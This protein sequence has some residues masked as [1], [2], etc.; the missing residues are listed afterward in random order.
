M[1]V[2]FDALPDSARIWIYQSNRELSLNEVQEIEDKATQFIQDWT[3]H[4]DN[5]KA[6]FIVKYQHFIIIAV[7]EGFNNASGCSI[8]A[9]VSFI[10]KLEQQFEIDLMNKLN[11]S[12][13]INNHINVVSLADFKNYIQQGK[14][15]EQTTVFNNLVT[16]IKEFKR[17]WE[18][19]AKDSW[20]NKLFKKL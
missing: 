4:G 16:N 15:S 6:S 12:F 20:H 3:A 5:L 8:D 1:L 14:I 9:S 11:I 7:D 13:K 2:E 19:E 17:N 18:V 10:K